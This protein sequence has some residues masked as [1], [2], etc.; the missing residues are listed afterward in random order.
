MLGQKWIRKNE[1]LKIDIKPNENLNVYEKLHNNLSYLKDSFGYKIK[2]EDDE[3]NI[4]RYYDD[5]ITNNEIFML[6]IYN[7][8]GINYN[9]DQESKKNLFDVY[10]NI[11]FPLISYDK[12]ENIISILNN[13][14]LSLIYF[15]ILIKK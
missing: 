15:L 9:P 6:D 10:I 5:F 12:Y 13:K 14:I 11:Y 2:R 3:T 8:L 1:L 4:I 7:E